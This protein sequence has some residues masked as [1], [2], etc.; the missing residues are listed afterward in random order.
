MDNISYFISMMP[1]PLADI[2]NAIDKIVLEKINEIRLRKNK[3]II[4]YIV[5][6]PY[7]IEF[8]GK[9]VERANKL[10]VTCDSDTFEQIC[11]R[12]CNHSYHTNM[13][14]LIDGYV[15]V[16]NG[17]RVGVASTAVIKDNKISSVKNISSINI[18][19]SH[20]YKGAADRILN[21]V[22][23][24]ELP[25][26]IVAGKVSSGKTTLLRDY[27]RQISS[28]YLGKYQK[29]AIID[30]RREIASGFDVGINTDILTGFNKAKGIEIATRT[31]SPDVIICDEVGSMDE[32]NAIKHSFSSGVKFAL[33]IHINDMPQ[34]FYNKILMDLINTN[35]FDYIIILKSFT[36]AF[37][38]IDL[39]E[40]NVENTG[41]GN[42]SGFF[43]LPWL[44]GDP[45]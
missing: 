5:N 37:E 19:I 24:K 3:L 1:T 10:C 32:L 15:T 35:E 28:G 14:T 25:S 45:K 22:Y 23:K 43:I 9:P 29:T 17:S 8:S 26:I 40:A 12:L 33:S 20:E 27:A 44:D 36:D 34:I 16:S 39:R 38:V 6:K 42:D 41:N 13:N 30:E 21:I 18:R 11:D 7:F 31:L 4:I 2:F